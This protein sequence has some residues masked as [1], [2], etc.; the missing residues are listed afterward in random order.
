MGRLLLTIFYPP[1]GGARSAP[2]I[3]CRIVWLIIEPV[4]S[5][6]LEDGFQRT[7]TALTALVSAKS[8]ASCASLTTLDEKSIPVVIPE[9]ECG[10][11][12]MRNPHTKLGKSM[13][14]VP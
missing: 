14:R 9:T 11:V 5:S 6:D 2:V 3:I 7:K 12:L 4:H 1:R 13:L 10:L 8:T